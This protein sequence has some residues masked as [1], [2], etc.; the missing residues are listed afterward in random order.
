MQQGNSISN[1][2]QKIENVTHTSQISF[3]LPPVVGIIKTR[4]SWKSELVTPSSFQNIEFL[5]FH[6]RC[7]K[8]KRLFCVYKM[9]SR[10]VRTLLIGTVKV[11][12][13]RNP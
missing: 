6:I 8:K 7:K 9:I 2:P 11:F 13:S 4:Q 10:L 3:K 12:C 5:K 1:D